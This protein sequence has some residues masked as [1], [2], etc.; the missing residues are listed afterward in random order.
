MLQTLGDLFVT[1]V[2][3]LVKLTLD[4]FGPPT[5]G[6]PESSDLPDSQT[7]I[8]HFQSMR[9]AAARRM[10]PAPQPPNAPPVPPNAPQVPPNVAPPPANA[11]T[12]HEPPAVPAA[13]APPSAA[14]IAQTPAQPSRF[15]RPDS[16]N[17]DVQMDRE[18]FEALRLETPPPG[19]PASVEGLAASPVRHG[20]IDPTL[21]HEFAIERAKEEPPPQSPAAQTLPLSPARSGRLDEQEVRDLPFV[22]ERREESLT[23]SWAR[24]PR[25][26]VVSTPPV[27]HAPAPTTPS[28]G[29]QT[30][31]AQPSPA[32]VPPASSSQIPAADA[33]P[34]STW[35]ELP[36]WP[37]QWD[38]PP[39]RTGRRFSAR[40]GT[41]YV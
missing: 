30:A 13:A 8:A 20:T 31:P 40:E 14:S 7:L 33:S 41:W 35:P 39:E 12:A 29:A 25:S 6:T 5:R 26:P 11:A 15:V 16:G 23:A 9:D 32:H 2:T 4:S 24:F 18:A 28:A 34:S 22:H 27:Q 3:T 1:V 36:E 21:A 37:S 19:A 38:E 10:P 17:A